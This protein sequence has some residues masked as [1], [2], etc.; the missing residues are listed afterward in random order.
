MDTRLGLLLLLLV[1]VSGCSKVEQAWKSTKKTASRAYESTKRTAHR[2]YESTKT[3]LA[4][5]ECSSSKDCTKKGRKVCHPKK[6]KCVACLNHQHCA[7]Q[8]KKTPICNEK[9]GVCIQCL[10]HQHCAARSREYPICNEKLGV[11]I[12]CQNKK[13]CRALSSKLK[14]CHRQR[15]LEC[16]QHKDCEPWQMCAPAGACKA[17]PDALLYATTI[18]FV[19]GLLFPLGIL[20]LGPSLPKLLFPLSLSC[21]TIGPMIGLFA[22][23]YLGFYGITYINTLLAGT[24]IFLGGGVGCLAALRWDKAGFALGLLLQSTAYHALLLYYQDIVGPNPLSLKFFV[25]SGLIVSIVL[26]SL[27]IDF[28]EAKD[29]TEQSKKK[30]KTVLAILGV[31]LTAGEIIGLVFQL[32]NYFQ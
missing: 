1:A 25:L 8:S 12:Q 23:S 32:M 3:L 15:C 6:R 16:L 10:S 20:L 2:A 22:P 26:F 19:L 9:L 13:D 28:S 5:Q 17:N 31:V 11:C 18:A 30:G 29:D 21:L 7:S 24:S 14:F 4:L 27:S